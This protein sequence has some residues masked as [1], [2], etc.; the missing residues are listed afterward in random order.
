MDHFRFTR[1]TAA[2]RG[3]VFAGQWAEGLTVGG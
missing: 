2:I 3:L 1:P